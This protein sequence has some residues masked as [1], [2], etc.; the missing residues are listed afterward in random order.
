MHDN[1]DDLWKDI[2]LKR[3]SAADFKNTLTLSDKSTTY[4]YQIFE[5]L[6]TETLARLY[7][8][9]DWKTSPIQHD[10]GVD[11]TA[12]KKV[13]NTNNS[14][15][16]PQLI[17]YGQIKRRKASISEKLVLD[18]TS[19]IIRYYRKNA[20]Q[21]KCLYEIIHVFSTDKNIISEIKKS[22][23]NIDNLHYC[24]RIINAEYLFKIWC[25]NKYF[26]HSIIDTALT[27][28]EIEL[29]D[30]FVEKNASSWD[31][32]LNFKKTIRQNTSV[33]KIFEC[34]VQID[35]LL[36]I[37]FSVKVKWLPIDDT[38]ILLVSPQSL[39]TSSPLTVKSINNKIIFEIKFIANSVVERNPACTGF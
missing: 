22:I 5:V 3:C 13:N 26:V 31:S 34:V 11:F 6:V 30:C 1:T 20:I 17:I 9:F 12:E 37:A 4:Q 35:S 38:S 24:V 14:D 27:R 2:L 10:G 32:V 28:K 25:L 23:E 36:D 8:D 16:F 33:G 39:L 18:A 29:L 7:N 21:K 15:Y 19:N